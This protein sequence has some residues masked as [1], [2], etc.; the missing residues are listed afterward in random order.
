MA[1]IGMLRTAVGVGT[2]RATVGAGILRTAIGVELPAAA[3]RVGMG[4]A[5]RALA[6]I[7]LRGLAWRALGIRWCAFDR[8]RAAAW[9]GT[10]VAAM[11][12]RMRAARRPA[13]GPVPLA[14]ARTAW[15]L[16]GAT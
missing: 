12:V 8:L 1:G 13:T 10:C 5:A 15:F 9:V 6:C 2:L 14:G 7:A 11:A 4:V 16:P 3:V